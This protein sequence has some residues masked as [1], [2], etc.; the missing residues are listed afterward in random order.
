MYIIAHAQYA[1]GKPDT[2]QQ[3]LTI[4]LYAA[5]I[6]EITAMA[7]EQK[8]Y[9]VYCHTNKINGKKYIG[10]TSQTVSERWGRHGEKYKS[11]KF[12]SA[13]AKYGWE[14]F[15]HEIL[16]VGLTATEAKDIEKKLIEKYKT[17]G[18]NGYNTTKGGDGIEGFRFPEKSRKKM[19]NSAKNRIDD[20]S[21]SE[22]YKK[23]RSIICKSKGQTVSTRP[24]VK[25]IDANGNIYDNILQASEALGINY[26]TLWNQI[27]GRRKNRSGVKIYE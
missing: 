4:A 13:I 7:N 12:G 3:N 25:V 14:N 20:R 19:S 2:K 6:K 26:H 8:K 23:S 21:K 10:I 24:P 18:K 11:Q 16:F 9:I 27:K 5:H 15:A 22:E 1:D 17:F